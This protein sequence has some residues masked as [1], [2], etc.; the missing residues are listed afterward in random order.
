MSIRAILR[1]EPRPQSAGEAR[2]FVASR[3]TNWGRA[4]DLDA[5][6]L[7]TSEVV[8]NVIVHAGPHTE[9]DEVVVR[10]E[11][12]I[13][14]LRVEVYDHAASLPVVSHENLDGISGRGLILLDAIARTWGVES[15]D[16]GKVVWF[17]V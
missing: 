14:R 8:T 11:G 3:L 16:R 7:L 13:G 10:L 17:E 2:R 12:G 5:V 6:V 4:E 15:T 9:G 1:I